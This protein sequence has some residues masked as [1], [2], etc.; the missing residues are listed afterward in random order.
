MAITIKIIP[1]HSF[2][3][4][5]ANSENAFN[6]TATTTDAN[7][8]NANFA[9]TEFQ[10]NVDPRYSVVNT[11]GRMDPIMNYQGTGR[12]I[13]FAIRVLKAGDVNDYHKAMKRIMYPSYEAAAGITNAL[14]IQR[15]PL[16]YVFLTDLIHDPD[17]TS[18]PLLCAIEN[19]TMS[20]FVGLTPI[21]SPL[22]RYGADHEAK[23]QFQGGT[24]SWSVVPLHT[25]TPG[26]N[27]DAPNTPSWLGGDNF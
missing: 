17:D 19:Y 23:V 9:L 6:Y 25:K 8:T 4:T 21:D 12:K 3:P 20:P 27:A 7:S 22:V 1:I 5:P 16:A 18:E 13:N 26:W 10:D 24:L 14:T 11:F 15:P 2:P